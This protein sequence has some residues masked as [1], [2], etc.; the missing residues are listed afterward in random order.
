MG[1]SLGT[2][3][4]VLF[5]ADLEAVRLQATK[6]AAAEPASGKGGRA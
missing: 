3:R 2:S 6:P 4:R 5:T 1:R